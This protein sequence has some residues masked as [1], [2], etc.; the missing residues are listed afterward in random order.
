LRRRHSDEDG[1]SVPK[2][3]DESAG[4]YSKSHGRRRQDVVPLE[5]GRIETVTE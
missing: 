2:K 1:N 4:V 3:H 5:P